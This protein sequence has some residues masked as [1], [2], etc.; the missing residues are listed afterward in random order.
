MSNLN[1]AS[2]QAPTPATPQQAPSSVQSNTQE[3]QPNTP[4]VV[5]PDPVAITKNL[6][7]KDLR[8]TIQV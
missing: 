8:H 4:T 5:P 1:P 2:Q 7:L 3:T 6:A